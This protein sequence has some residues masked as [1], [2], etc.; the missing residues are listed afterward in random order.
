MAR[1][2]FG[3]CGSEVGLESL[4][5]DEED[6]PE[7]RK[8]FDHGFRTVARMRELSA[9]VIDDVKMPSAHSS[10]G[11]APALMRRIARGG[12]QVAEQHEREDDGR[13][14]TIQP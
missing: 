5:D 10:A 3:C 14:S 8:L 4:Y 12:F 11:E 6:D 9:Y 13:S 2:A 7:A 1:L